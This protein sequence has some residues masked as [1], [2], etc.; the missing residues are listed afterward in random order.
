MFLFA[1]M[2]LVGYAI[3][4]I[5]FLKL[6]FTYKWMRILVARLKMVVETYAQRD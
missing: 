4:P 5:G 3:K 1:V 2:G 6:S